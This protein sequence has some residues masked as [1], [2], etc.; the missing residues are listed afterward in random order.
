MLFQGQRNYYKLIKK[1]FLQEILYTCLKHFNNSIGK[2]KFGDRVEGLV[3]K[4]DKS[5]VGS[6]SPLKKIFAVSIKQESYLL[7][8][9]R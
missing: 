4:I 3:A 1:I 8:L 5:F 7:T 2:A 6:S 9:K